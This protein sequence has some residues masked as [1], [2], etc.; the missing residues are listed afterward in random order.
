M[1]RKYK[2][3]LGLSLTAFIWGSG[4]IGVSIALSGGLTPLQILTIRFF[5]GAVLIGVIFFKEIKNNITKEAI[6]S[7]SIIGLFLFIAF[8]FQTFGM[9]YTTAS[10]NA[11]L[12]AINVVIVPFIGFIL[13]KRP[14]DKYG[15]ISS[16]I[17]ILG[18]GILSLEADFS[19]NLGDFLTIICAFGFAFHIFFTG[20]FVKKYNPVVLTVVQF[21][22][23]TV[24]SL[25]VQILFNEVR[26]NA[27]MSSIIGVLYLGIFS[28]TIAFLLQTICQKDVSETKSAIILALESV[29]GTILSVIIL[30]EVLTVRMVIGCLIIFSAIIISE[31]KLSFLKRNNLKQEKT[32]SIK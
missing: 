10:K 23:A 25:V 5:I 24:L 27:E 2:G 11:F 22:V 31:T 12:T 16:I 7:G 6:I 28:T 4:F 20:E 8:A 32:E 3:E 9:A 18:I 1:F 26:I 17:A 15:I 21:S 30:H 19:I 14:L 29:F 13:Y